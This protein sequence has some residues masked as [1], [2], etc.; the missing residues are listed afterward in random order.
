MGR[1]VMPSFF[2]R[3][4]SVE[5]FIPRHAAAPFFSGRLTEALVRPN[6][7]ALTSTLLGAV[8]CYFGGRAQH[9]HRDAEGCAAARRIV[10]PST[11]GYRVAHE[12][13][14]R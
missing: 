13:G 8:T 12:S 4:F 6:V 5:R 3:K 1:R 11:A 10:R 2:S 9:V 14:Q 7:A